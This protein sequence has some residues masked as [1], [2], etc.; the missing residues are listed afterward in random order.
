M[1]GGLDMKTLVGRQK[2]KLCADP[3]K[4]L[5]GCGRTQVLDADGQTS[6]WA[7]DMGWA[8]WATKP[9][10]SPWLLSPHLLNGDSNSVH[11]R[12]VSQSC[13]TLCDPMDCS[14]Q[15]PLSM[16]FFSGENIGVGCHFLFRGIFPTQGS[17]LHLLCLLHCQRTLY[18]LSHPSGN[19]QLRKPTVPET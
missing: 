19:L 1:E 12:L 14:H 6:A 2:T 18:L 8:S 13:L 10:P 7:E 15:A 4:R 3:S 11:T 16:T 17:Y 5:G 9:E